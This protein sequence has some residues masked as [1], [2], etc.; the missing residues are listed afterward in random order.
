[1]IKDFVYKLKKK[2]ISGYLIHVLDPIEINFQIGKN[3]RLSDL[4]TNKSLLIGNSNFLKE[5]Y[6]ENLNKLILELTDLAKKNNWN[7]MLHNNEKNL[8]KF[9][10]KLVQ[11]ILL[12]KNKIA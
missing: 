11:N 6:T 4:E 10:L 9:I 7:Y 3:I 12:K 1:M 8:N 2:N 5:K